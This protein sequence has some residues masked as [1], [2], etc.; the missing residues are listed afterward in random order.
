MSIARRTVLNAIANVADQLLTGLYLFVSYGI[1][2]REAGLEQVAL[3]SLALIIGNA[4]Q[5][6]N[7]SLGTGLNRYLPGLSATD[8]WQSV[9]NYTE[10]AMVFT[11]LFFL[12]FA[13]VAYYPFRYFLFSFV[14]NDMMALAAAMIV[15][16]IAF[17]VL[18]NVAMVSQ[19]A[20][21]ALQYGVERSAISALSQIVG[22]IGTIWLVPEYGAIAAIWVRVAQTAF[23]LLVGWIFLLFKIP[24]LRILPR[25]IDVTI[26]RKLFGTGMNMQVMSICMI[27][28][29]PT[30]RALIGWFGTMEQVAVFA[31][32]WRLVTQVRAIIFYA[33]AAVMPALGF[34]AASDRDKQLEFYRR[35]NELIA[36]FVIPAMMGSVAVAPLIGYLW[37]GTVVPDFA[38]YVAI[39]TIGFLPSTI[40][41]GSYH[42]SLSMGAFRYNLIGHIVMAAVNLLV[43]WVLGLF[44][45]GL[46][47]AIGVGLGLFL[48]GMILGFGNWKLMNTRDHGFD[49]R[50]DLWAFVMASLATIGCWV[51]AFELGWFDRPW[52]LALASIGACVM[53]MA[54]AAWMHAGRQTILGA[55]R[56]RRL[57]QEVDI[58]L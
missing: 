26:A 48:Q 17:A 27:L 42:L 47:V 24:Q 55:W 28:L 12:L 13:V 58:V 1:L 49:L 36:F 51:L 45:G 3:L 52:T 20:M 30:S 46:G 34:L 56:S 50:A 2:A 39:M 43:G 6:S 44:I 33:S 11:I 32:A 57:V 21:G 53:L 41:L 29:E 16:A 9:K 22:L 10:S 15:P 14:E 4:A 38:Y 18:Q 40:T 5:T 31:L 35:S 7:I 8:D 54:P 25:K 23:M 19:A 37:L